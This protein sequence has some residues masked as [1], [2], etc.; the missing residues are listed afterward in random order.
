MHEKKTFSY[1]VKRLK[2]SL[3]Q[4]ETNKKTIAFNVLFSPLN[5]EQ[6]KQAYISKHNS[7]HANHE[8]LLTVTDAEN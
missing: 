5:C 4:I 1:G 8:I 3:K 2:K 6:I 7:E